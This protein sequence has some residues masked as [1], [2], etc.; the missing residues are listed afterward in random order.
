V[1]GHRLRRFVF[2]VALLLAADRAGAQSR[3]REIHDQPWQVV[4]LLEDA[5]LGASYIF[6]IDFTPDGT[7]WLATNVGLYRYDGYVWQRFT[8]RDG[9]PTD[10]VRSV[11]V[12]RSGDLWVGTSQGAGVF[13]GRRFDRRGSDTGL[14]GPSVRRI[15]EDPD[16]TIWF[17]SDRWP[18][19]A[20]QGGLTMLHRGEWRRFG[21]AEGITEGYVHHYFRESH[22]RQFALAL[23]GIFERTGDRWTRLHEPGLPTDAR[24]AWQMVELPSGDLVVQQHRR[25]LVRRA[26][27]WTA[28][29]RERAPMIVARSGELVSAL[30]TPARRTLAFERW[31][32]AGFVRAS[33]EASI[34]DSPS[35]MV[36]E[37]PDGSIWCVGKGILL[38]WRYRS[39]TWTVLTGLP[40][41]QG[42]DARGRVWFADATSAWVVRGGDPEPLPH[43]RAPIHFVGADAWA[44]S[45]AGFVRIADRPE[46]PAA[47]AAAGLSA[48][49]AIV[50]DPDDRSLWFSGHDSRDEPAIRSF[51]GVHWR[52]P[53]P[54]IPA[55]FAVTMIEPDPKRGIWLTMYGV[56]TSR[57]E[58]GRVEQDRLE[59][60][61][62]GLPPLQRPRIAARPEGFCLYDYTGA[63]F[64]TDPLQRAWRRLELPLE[65]AASHFTLPDVTWFTFFGSRPTVRG[66][67]SYRSGAWR[68]VAVDWRGHAQPDAEQSLLLPA[69][70]G[71]YIVRNDTAA[72]PLFVA[73]PGAAAITRVARD[74]SGVFW[75]A[76]NDYTLRHLPDRTP[77][78]VTATSA[79]AEVRRDRELHVAFEAR[80]RYEPRRIGDRF[81]FAWRLDE[82]PWSRFEATDALTLPPNGAARGAHRLQVRAR[83]PHGAVSA[84]PAELRFVV[85]APPLQ[86]RRWFWPLIAGLGLLLVYMT[87]AASSA[88]AHL[89]RLARGLEAKVRERTEQLEQD[90]DRRQRAEAALRDSEQRFKGVFHSAFQLIGV[91]TPTGVV[92]EANQ[93]ALEVIGARREDVVGRPLWETR[94]WS[95]PPELQPQVRDAI[96]RAARGELVRFEAQHRQH[97][98]GVMIVDCSFKAVLDEAGEVGFLI[99]EGR[100]ITA[101]KLG[102][103]DRTRL[104]TQL[105]QSQKMEAIGTL[106]GGVAHDFNNLL[107]PIFGNAEI[108]KMELPA[109]H[110]VQ[111]R[112]EELLQAAQRARDLV[113]QI[114]AFSRRQEQERRPLQLA[115]V[116][117]EALKL[118]RA[119]LPKTI[120]IVAAAPEDLPSVLAD[121]GQIH[122][123]VMNLCTNA[124]HAMRDDSGRLDVSLSLVRVDVDFARLHP[125]LH[126]R[127]YVRLSVTDN[128]V[129]IEA[130]TLERIFEPFFSTKPTGKGTGL[131]LSVVHGIMENHDGTITVYS[132]P[133]RGTTFHLYFP[134]LDVAAAE[135]P[136]ISRAAP[137]GAG[138]QILVVDDEAAV[139]DIAVRMLVRAGYAA[140]SYTDPLDALS[141]FA[142]EPDRF[143]MVLTDLTMPRL[144]GLDLARELRRVRPEIP[145]VLGS[146]FSDELG[147]DRARDAG[148]SELIMKPYTM[149]DLAEVVHR[150]LARSSAAD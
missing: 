112:L 93:T 42:A 58:L 62:D 139:G 12:T 40:A 59:R 97:D 150:V 46:A 78:A 39:P 24:P 45:A 27:Q 138:E 145:I 75:I 108:A 18:D 142:E 98:G 56:G 132:Q 63:Y 102:E 21:R 149:S 88:R 128:G 148:I 29:P 101:R 36:R 20:V 110:P 4:S 52:S 65:S 81:E 31:T 34:Y 17:S 71:F 28:S 144:T 35:E 96:D 76:T 3:L 83:D 119:S 15:V 105:R 25:V 41:E 134:A 92:Q 137:R 73:V 106:A 67:A 122:Q 64:A 94:W 85:L 131:G 53:S 121:P 133:G 8:T 136:A 89:A 68:P 30:E 50:Q 37:A 124:A 130:A 51:D 55:G 90:I 70:G 100:D 49:T 32:S 147:A 54:T 77:L 116:V 61:A 99:A 16:G 120:E 125:R 69:V 117:V 129:G 5:G 66:V 87:A 80:R 2:I 91:L 107:T 118:M 33:A 1:T 48:I 13:D 7:A 135:L 10:F 60:F 115:P 74:L 11:L 111:E 26:G 38:R 123:I 23:D 104:E 143:A 103:R 109:D 6:A 146:G 43:L 44:N 57:W 126:A 9:L 95:D 82:G 140:R 113:N 141:A 14:A 114:L 79:L 127:P 72:S 84:R 86:E 47:H 22:G 19:V